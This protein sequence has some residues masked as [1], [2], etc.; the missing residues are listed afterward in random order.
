MFDNHS[1]PP[2]TSAPANLPFG[3]PEDMFAAGGAPEDFAAD[4]VPLPAA[5]PSSDP[6]EILA[7]PAVALP[8]ALGA[9]VLRP[10]VQPIEPLPEPNDPFSVR[11]E[12]VPP[13][14]QNNSNTSNA[15][16]F[17]ETSVLPRM[18]ENVLRAPM[19]G[20]AVWI[21]LATL[22]SLGIV[23]GAGAWVYFTYINPAPTTVLPTQPTV[24]VVNPTSTPVNTIIEDIPSATSTD[25]EILFG[26]SILDTDSD[27]LDDSYEKKNGTDMLLWD[28]DGD[29][30]SDGDEIMTWK[31]NPTKVDTDGDTYADG[32]EIRNGY[33]PRG[34]GKLFPVTP[35]ATST[36]SAN[37]TTS[38][39]PKL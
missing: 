17:P 31:T 7:A 3:E 24:P 15:V 10:R 27:G 11:Q 16:P 1:A 14:P 21:T 12:R 8:T 18:P 22:I 13:A 29:G 9:G 19:G 33:N 2:N 35:T 6:A 34:D 28:T 4:P 20:R 26:D 30:L 5:V 39:Q 37:L 32:M 23:G 25:S 36:S 38:T